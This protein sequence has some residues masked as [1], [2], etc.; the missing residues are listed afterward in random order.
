[1]DGVGM[2][3]GGFMTG[4]GAFGRGFTHWLFDR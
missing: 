2:G 1:M 3:F 4:W